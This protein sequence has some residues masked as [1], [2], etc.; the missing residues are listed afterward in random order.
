MRKY[1]S[2][3]K[4]LWEFIPKCN[5][6][7]SWA[8]T[9]L[10]ITHTK[11]GKQKLDTNKIQRKKGGEK[12]ACWGMDPERW[13]DRSRSQNSSQMLLHKCRG[14]WWGGTGSC[15]RHTLAPG[16]AATSILGFH[17]GSYKNILYT[18]VHWRHF[19]SHQKLG[20]YSVSAGS[21]TKTQ[22]KHLSFKSG[23]AQLF[24]WMINHIVLREKG[25]TFTY[26][27]LQL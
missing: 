26:P 8:S 20:V 13:R 27:S 24:E 3:K 23:R 6:R 5:S 16:S 15:H 10:Q 9:S 18:H 22:W 4:L 25:T 7:V 12:L 1:P 11:K 2:L 14:R 21:A 17:Q 19:K